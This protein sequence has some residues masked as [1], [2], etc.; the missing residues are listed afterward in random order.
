MREDFVSAIQEK[1][2]VILHFF[3]KEDNKIISRKC[4]PMDIGPS[5]LAKNKDDRYHFWD[6]ESDTKNHTLSLL[7]EQIQSIVVTSEFFNPSEFVTWTPSWIIP[8]D[9]GRYS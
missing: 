7:P 5:S 2:K 9:W 6:Y 8:R 3:S 4:A 1:R